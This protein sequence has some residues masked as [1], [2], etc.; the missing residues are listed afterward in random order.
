MDF[1]EEILNSMAWKRNFWV[2]CW[3]WSTQLLFFVIFSNFAVNFNGFSVENWTK[4]HQF[5]GISLPFSYFLI[6]ILIF[7]FFWSISFREKEEK[8]TA[9]H[10]WTPQKN[11]KYS[12]REFDGLVKIW[13]TKLHC[14]DPSNMNYIGP[15]NEDAGKGV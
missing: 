15:S 13:R 10:P 12:R 7:F 2:K 3:L 14:Y 8:R 9:D 4:C 11:L 5:D 1:V 6:K